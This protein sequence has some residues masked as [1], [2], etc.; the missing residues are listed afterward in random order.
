MLYINSKK[1]KNKRISYCWRR[2]WRGGDYR[3]KCKVEDFHPFPVLGMHIWPIVPAWG[4]TS[5]GMKPWGNHVLS[6]PFELYTWLNPIKAS[7]QTLKI[8]G[9]RCTEL[10]IM[11]L[12]KTSILSSL[13][14]LNLPPT[15]LEWP[16]SFFSLSLLIVYG[17]L[18]QNFT[19]ETPEVVNQ[20]LRIYNSWKKY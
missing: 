19:R 14:L 6:R 20:H 9:A 17:G 2:S 5:S 8:L 1:T 7:T 4:A 13:G 18:V 10:L 3:L 15:N 16:A 12:P 11:P